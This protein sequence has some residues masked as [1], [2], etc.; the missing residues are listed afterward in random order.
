LESFI[1][2]I[3][4]A[5]FQLKEQDREK[6]REYWD[7]Y[8]RN[9]HEFLENGDY[10]DVKPTEIEVLRQRFASYEGIA[11]SCVND[12]FDFL[13][14][15]HTAVAHRLAQV[16]AA[17]AEAALQREDFS[18][19]FTG[20]ARKNPQ[21]VEIEKYEGR[22]SV[23]RYWH[24]A[25]WFLT[26]ERDWQLLHSSVEAGLCA[27]SLDLLHMSPDY[28]IAMCVESEMYDEAI[29]ITRSSDTKQYHGL[30]T[31][32]E[33]Q[34]GDATKEELA[35]EKIEYWYYQSRKWRP[36]RADLPWWNRLNW[37]WLHGCYISGITELQPLL[38]QLKGY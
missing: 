25:H 11:N 35:R 8:E 38:H 26:G 22:R 24:Y 23:Y 29:K 2:N 19:I 5:K 15:G 28:L 10:R 17:S 1:P 14:L 31:V 7:I 32:A 34:M 18:R 12:S 3:Q 6:N 13:T 9:Y 36:L 4:M 37:A 27:K 20:E 21:F 30:V 16:A 33:W